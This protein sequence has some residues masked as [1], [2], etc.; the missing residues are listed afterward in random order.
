MIPY[1]RQY[2]PKKDF[3][4]V[5]KVLNSNFLTQGPVVKKF[6][7]KI[8]NFTNSK[9][10]LALNSATSALHVSC[11][12]LGLKKGDYLWTSSISFVASANCGV[13][14]GAKVDLIDIDKD[15]FNLSIIDLKKKLIV[16]KLEKKLPKILV[17]VHLGGNPCDLKEIKKLSKKYKFKVI[18][19][20]SHAFGSKYKKSKIGSCKYSDMTVFSL[21]PVKIITSGEGGVITTNSK[22]LARKSIL[23][24]EHGI[25]RDSKYFIDKKKKLETYYEQQSLGF[26][27]RMNELSAS[28]GLGQINWTKKFISKRNKIHKFYRDNFSSLPIKFQKINEDCL[29]SFHL[30]VILVSKKIRNALFSELRKKKY[31][32]NIHYI[33][34]FEQPFY[35]K[36]FHKKDFINSMNYYESAISIPNY[37]QLGLF[38][39]KKI[40]N[41]IKKF[42]K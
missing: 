4:L 26:N 18:E 32:V 38:H 16:A 15:T 9:Y 34:I 27:Y 24:R 1:S 33:P 40:V 6:E 22:E 37:Y 3:K 39:Q 25:V 14:C 2:V 10:A 23:F 8:S 12:A 30:S 29:S 35:K 5:R 7:K 20:A 11:L 28:V 19:D 41:I 42:V 21:H 31:L 17:V 13:Y 36:N